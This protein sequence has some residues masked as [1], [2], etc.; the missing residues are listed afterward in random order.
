M[1]KLTL[2]GIQWLGFVEGVTSPWFLS[3]TGNFLI[4]WFINMKGGDRLKETI[5]NK[6]ISQ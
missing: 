1:F 4:I 3:I 2:C 5:L 6:Y